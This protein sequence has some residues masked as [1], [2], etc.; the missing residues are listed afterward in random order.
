MKAIILC[1]DIGDAK[2]EMDMIDSSVFEKC[3]EH[4]GKPT[5][6]EAEPGRRRARKRRSK[7]PT[8]N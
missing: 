7:T 1:Y 6:V 2:N 3:W 4:A 5:A 8:K